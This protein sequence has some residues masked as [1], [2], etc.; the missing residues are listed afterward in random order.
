[1]LQ[2]KDGVEGLQK[3]QQTDVA[4][5]LCDLEMPGMNGF[6]FL[7]VRQQTPELVSIP[8]IMLTSR[9]GVKHQQ[10]AQE[11]GATSYLTKPYLAPQLLATLAKVLLQHPKPEPLEMLKSIH[12]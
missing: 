5:I 2:A 8:T 10:L 4:A 3:L 7:K 1:M 11:L 12:G 6:E 9:T